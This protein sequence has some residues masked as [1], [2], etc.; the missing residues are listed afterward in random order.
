MIIGVAM[1]HPDVYKYSKAVEKRV[2]Q[3]R[4]RYYL[5]FGCTP[6]IGGMSRGFT[7]GCNFKCNMCLSPFR[8]FLEGDR[9]FLLYSMYDEIS[10]TRGFYSPE[11]VIEILASNEKRK[12]ID[13]I[14]MFDGVK[15][16]K[17]K[18]KYLDVGY[19]EISLGRDHLLGLCRAASK[20]GYI[21]VVETNG[22]MVGYESDYA[23]ALAEYK[24]SILVRVGVK[25]A[26]PEM[27]KKVIGVSNA[28]EYVFKGIQYL[29][30]AGLDVNVAMMCD[31]RIYSNEEK[32]LMQRKI[33]ES[34]YMGEIHEEKI[35][36]YYTAY[37][38]FV[39]SGYDPYLLSRNNVLEIIGKRIP[40]TYQL[41]RINGEN[42]LLP[43]V[44]QKMRM[45]N[46]FFRDMLT[47]F[48][49]EAAE[50][51]NE[52]IE[53]NIDGPGGGSWHFIVLDGSCRLE[54]GMALQK[55][56][57]S[58]TMDVDTAYTCFI[59]RTLDRTQ[60]FFNGRISIEG[61]PNLSFSIFEIFNPSPTALVGDEVHREQVYAE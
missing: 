36:N 23:A 44:G 58:I 9:R 16:K 57:I 18:Y 31:P 33:R 34:G 15:P 26:S 39:E 51:L 19:A 4:D 42:I 22:F 52:T 29:V 6:F 49:A 50:G 61:N 7:C 1:A 35:F 27:Y 60:A 2:C 41:E 54:K 30:E 14:A 28:G 13:E 43:S 21:F 24:D 55:P 53:Y 38:R 25:A 8:D 17:S 11:Q 45:L 47:N 5:Y 3:G 46:D 48:N 59:T 12:K 20:T 40:G 10:K 32:Q 37:K 56:G